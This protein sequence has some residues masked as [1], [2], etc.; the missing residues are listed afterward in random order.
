MTAAWAAEIRG[1]G[2]GLAVYTVNEPA[3]A[4]ELM[5]FGVQCIISDAP[6]RILAAV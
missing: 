6:D 5:G 3:R 1:L 2:Y 4:R